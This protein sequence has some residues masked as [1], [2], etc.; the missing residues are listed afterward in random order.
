MSNLQ[1]KWEASSSTKG[2]YEE[3]LITEFVSCNGYDKGRSRV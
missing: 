3:Y 2:E 1:M